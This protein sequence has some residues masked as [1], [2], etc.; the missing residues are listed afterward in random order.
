MIVTC[1][2]C[3]TRFKI[4]DEKVSSRGVKVRC[5]K[6]KHTFTV[7][8]EAEPAAP[9]ASAPVATPA[10]STLPA[11]PAPVQAAQKPLPPPPAVPGLPVS[12]PAQG[13]K[14]GA[15]QTGAALPPPPVKAQSAF[16]SFPPPAAPKPPPASRA[17]EPVVPDLSQARESQVK[18][19]GAGFVDDLFG[20]VAEVD[21]SRAKPAR[22]PA[23]SQPTVDDPGG[24]GIDLFDAGPTAGADPFSGIERD[25]P[26]GPVAGGAHEDPFAGIDTEVAPGG[27]AEPEAPPSAPPPLPAGPADPFAG[28]GPGAGADPFAGFDE[29]VPAAAPS[30][31]GAD[32]FASLDSAPGAEADPFGG[33][34]SSQ[35]PGADADPFGGMDSSQGQGAGADPFER[36]DAS[37]PAAGPPSAGADPFERFDV[38]APAA[39]PPSAGA[40]PFAGFDVSEPASPPPGPDSFGGGADPFGGLDMEPQS[41]QSPRGQA[42]DPDLFSAEDL[43]GQST[44]GDDPFTS[45]DTTNEMVD[46]DAFGGMP[47]DSMTGSGLELSSEGRLIGQEPPRPPPPMKSSPPMQDAEPAPAPVF[48]APLPAPPV[49]EPAP[50]PG[51]LLVYK[52]VFGTVVVLLAF[53][54]FIVYRSGGKL[55]LTDPATYIEAFTGAQEG[56]VGSAD[57]EMLSVTHTSYPNRHGHPLVLIWGRARNTTAEEKKGVTAT[58]QVIDRKGDVV[59]ELA[60]PVGVVF[61][62]PEVYGFTDP[63]AVGEAYRKGYAGLKS[64][65]IPPGAETAFMVVLHEHP[66]E[67][68]GHRL[69]AVLSESSDP[70]A[71]LPAPALPD[72]SDDEGPAAGEGAGEAGSPAP[73]DSP[74]PKPAGPKPAGAKPAGVKPAGPKPA[75]AK[76]AGAKPAEPAGGGPDAAAGKVQKKG[77]FVRFGP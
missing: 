37:A 2:Q 42:G 65:G 43:G 63:Q 38:S 15:P 45:F 20:G 51:G 62:P 61:T 34:D 57:I 71:G 47:A 39:G 59:A 9:E 54:V 24:G 60:V 68:D 46:P 23:K 50:S 27:L 77:T 55:D 69:R 17:I 70:L 7:R 10:P 19:V 3:G 8:R 30:S 52:I 64:K 67:M 12:A 72:V 40:D 74:G 49:E 18:R 41:Q 11:P 66:A 28:L 32:P 22:A 1:P 33:M 26:S 76:P 44:A 25:R 29:P 48:H 35:G 21:V 75:G 53:F 73:E 31:A 14:P 13:T 36:F 6:C 56:S 16:A 4:A 58:G 5:S